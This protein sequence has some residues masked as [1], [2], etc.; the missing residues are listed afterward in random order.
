[1]ANLEMLGEALLDFQTIADLTT[2]LQQHA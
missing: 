1:V 2:W